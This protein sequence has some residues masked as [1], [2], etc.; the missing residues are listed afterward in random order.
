MQVVA[1]SD[2]KLSDRANSAT[3]PTEPRCTSTTCKPFKYLVVLQARVSS[4]GL[5]WRDSP[6]SL[7]SVHVPAGS[8][9]PGLINP[10][11]LLGAT[12]DASLWP[13]D[14]PLS[15][16][17]A[18]QRSRAYAQT[19][20]FMKLP[21]STKSFLDTLTPAQLR[22]FGCLARQ[23]MLESTHPYYQAVVARAE[24]YCRDFKAAAAPAG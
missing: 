10:D 9:T 1:R 4:Q 14:L 23:H 17:S 16:A 22:E 5:G 11:E 15:A 3:T 20:W 18:E 7:S 21:W 12:Q 13:E 19:C 8:L 6:S 2:H 24:L